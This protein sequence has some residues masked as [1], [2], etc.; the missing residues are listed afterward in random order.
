[1]TPNFSLSELITWPDHHP[2][3]D[4]DT[5]LAHRLIREN[6]TLEHV[7][8]AQRITAR[9]QEVRNDFA[10]AFG[11]TPFIITC[12]LRPIAWE[13]HR[14]RSGNSQ[15][16]TGNAIDFVPRLWQPQHREWMRERL[17][18]WNGGMKIYNT[19]IHIDLGRK[20]RW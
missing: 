3:S 18:D 17:H 5:A 1:M 10:D 19:F 12:W 4:A 8:Q 9:L 2:M 14:N 15:H 6:I 20:R 11:D 16:T 7:R 13:Q